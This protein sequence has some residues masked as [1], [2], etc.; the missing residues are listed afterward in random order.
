[1]GGSTTTRFRSRITDQ[2]RLVLDAIGI[3]HPVSQGVIRGLTSSE[4]NSHSSSPTRKT[5]PSPILAMK[6][7]LIKSK[8]QVILKHGCGFEVEHKP[9][10]DN[11]AVPSNLACFVIGIPG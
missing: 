9:K 6:L 2:I 5:L 10:V 4:A 3:D 1:M 11:P 7:I 8:H